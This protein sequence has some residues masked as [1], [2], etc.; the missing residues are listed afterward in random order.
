MLDVTMWSNKHIKKLGMRIVVQGI[1]DFAFP[2]K[3][4]A[5]KE[6]IKR[7]DKKDPMYKDSVYRLMRQERKRIVKELKSSFISLLTDGRSDDVV[8]K[9]QK[10][11]DDKTGKSMEALRTRMRSVN[12]DD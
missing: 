8:S 6:R 1:R 7:L 11:L 4:S 10:I 3:M 12:S 2:E 9:L 5:V